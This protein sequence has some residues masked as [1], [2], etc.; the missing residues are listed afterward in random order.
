MAKD[1]KG[2]GGGLI[3]RFYLF[4]L[5]IYAELRIKNRDELHYQATRKCRTLFSVVNSLS[6]LRPTSSQMAIVSPS[7][8]SIAGM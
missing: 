2:G 1:R 5:E 8:L 6:K 4:L 7:Y 3:L